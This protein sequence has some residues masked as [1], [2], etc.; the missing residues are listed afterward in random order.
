MLQKTCTKRNALFDAHLPDSYIISDTSS[1]TSLT[2]KHDKQ[3]NESSFIVI[4]QHVENRANKRLNFQIYSSK[5][6]SADPLYKHRTNATTFVLQKKNSANKTTMSTAQQRGNIKSTCL[7]LMLLWVISG[8]CSII[9]A[10]CVCEVKDKALP[11]AWA[12][13][14]GKRDV[15]DRA[16]SG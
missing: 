7:C 10:K 5:F 14:C 15:C 6:H 8:R 2:S 9:S 4:H 16:I 13:V 1:S 12:T 3:T 11:K